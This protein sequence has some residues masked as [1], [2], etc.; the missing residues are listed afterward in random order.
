MSWD[1]TRSIPWSKIN[2]TPGIDPDAHKEQVFREMQIE[3]AIE[4][5]QSRQ[6]VTE[7]DESAA[8]K[9]GLPFSGVAMAKQAAFGGCIGTRADDGSRAFV[10]C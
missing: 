9:E 7:G 10:C 8:I 1:R 4:E 6:I 5:A 2:Q 3:A